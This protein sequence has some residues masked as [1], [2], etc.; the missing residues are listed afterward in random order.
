[1]EGRKTLSMTASLT[2]QH[3]VKVTI[4]LASV[5]LF[6]CVCSC[7]LANGIKGERQWR[8]NFMCMCGVSET[9]CVL[10]WLWGLGH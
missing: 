5:V 8:G 4:V 6:V 7:V 3:W 2:C 10:A 1:M 9:L